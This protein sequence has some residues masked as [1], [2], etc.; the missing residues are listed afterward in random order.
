MGIQLKTPGEIVCEINY[1]IVNIARKIILKII[2]HLRCHFSLIK[3]Y[4]Y[5]ENLVVSV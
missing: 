5:S 1:F 2:Q 3:M 4:I